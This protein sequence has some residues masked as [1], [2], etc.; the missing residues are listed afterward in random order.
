MQRTYNNKFLIS[1][2]N[3]SLN[4]I[5]KASWNDLQRKIKIIE[6]SH[7]IPSNSIIKHNNNDSLINN[8][9]IGTNIQLNSYIIHDCINHILIFFVYNFISLCYCFFLFFMLFTNINNTI[10]KTRELF[11]AKYYEE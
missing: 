2:L 9:Y 4:E 7:S 8:N 3:N 1:N 5:Y 11:V 10:P 6:Q